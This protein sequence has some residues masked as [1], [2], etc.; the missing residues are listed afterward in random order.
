[1]RWLISIVLLLQGCADFGYYWHSARGHL[2]VM[3]QRIDI[4]D[5]FEDE[6]LDTKLR[7]RLV[8]VGEIRQF[9]VDRLSL[10][11]NDSYHSYVQLDRPYVLQNL[12]AAPEFSTRLRQWCYP[13]IGCASY[14]GY[15]DEARLERYLEKLKAENLDIHIGRVAAYSTL[16]W[17]DDPVLSSFVYWPEHRLAGL[18]FHELTH[19]QL[20]IDDDTTFN[21]S[22]AT[23]VQQ[24]GIELWLRSR[25]RFAQL[26]R[27]RRW[28]EYRSRV[29]TLIAESRTELETIYAQEIDA[30]DKRLRKALILDRARSRHTEIARAHGIES[31]F[32]DWFASGLNNAKIGSVGAYNDQ[33]PAFRSILRAH[34]N[35]FERFF[36]YV[37][38][39]ARLDKPARDL[40]LEAWLAKTPE[41]ECR[42]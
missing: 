31:G 9:A 6:R 27:Y 25:E 37:E 12:F 29:M 23:A 22:L 3:S 17:F 39:L 7:E 32:T 5:L 38:R 13:L 26:D 34:D 36:D 24:A 20:Y 41:T 15:Y 19:E 30:E 33:L 11:D 10:P 40:C 2:A 42:L 18:L 1:M 28:L 16:G 14:R 35:D 4:E 21:E 8:L